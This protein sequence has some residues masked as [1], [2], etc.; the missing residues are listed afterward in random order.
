MFLGVLEVPALSFKKLMPLYALK[1]GRASYNVILGRS[2]LAD[3]IVTFDG[4][5]G[6]FH[7]S[8]PAAPHEPEVFDE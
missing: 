4:P 7:F 8:N 5:N 1:V 6:C 3:Y 2:F